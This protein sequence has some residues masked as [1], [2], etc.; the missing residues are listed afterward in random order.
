MA[1]G[2][3]PIY[4]GNPDVAREFNSKSCINCHDYPDIDSVINTI[5]AIDNDD[6]LFRQYLEEPFF[7]DNQEPV[8]LTAKNILDRFE[9]IF[10][11]KKE[12]ASKR[13]DALRKYVLFLEKGWEK[14]AVR[15]KCRIG[16]ST[17]RIFNRKKLK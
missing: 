8:S 10:R 17:T 3:I 2:T 6:D 5:I 14:E 15:L 12:H 4:W 13:M 11:N 9:I 16:M 1:E 7:P